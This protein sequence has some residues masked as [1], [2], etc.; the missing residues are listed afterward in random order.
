MS[1]GFNSDPNALAHLR[2][3]GHE[4]ITHH[5]ERTRVPSAAFEAEGIVCNGLFLSH[6]VDEFQRLRFVQL[7]SAGL[8]R[9]PVKE[10]RERGIQ[11]FHAKDVYSVPIAEWVVMQML[12]L[13]KRAP[14]FQENQ[15][16]VRWEKARD[17]RELSGRKACIIGFGSIGMEVAKRLQSFG[18]HI[19]GVRRSFTESP[20]TGEFVG[21]ESLNDV[22]P[23]ADFV[24]LS[25]PLNSE[26][27]HLVDT[28]LI[29]LMKDDAVLINVSRG[30]IIETDSLINAL[31]GGKFL[32]VALDVFEEEPLPADSVLWGNKRVLI[33]PHNSFV[34]DQVQPRL[35][36][37]LLENLSRIVDG[38]SEV[39]SV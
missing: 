27:R 20:A 36:K 13:Y 3:L 6:R 9:A 39:E 8:D 14:F 33:T 18:V 15:L 25:L 19:V 24:I 31:E 2:L 11:L 4:V 21:L 26:S 38:P 5:D 28:A 7:T 22:L 23:T 10:L 37:L 29:E 34:S 35:F 32:G 16:D 30:E 12:S 17:L 1:S